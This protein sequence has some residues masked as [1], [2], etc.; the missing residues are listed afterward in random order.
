MRSFL[1]HIFGNDISQF[2]NIISLNTFIFVLLNMAASRKTRFFLEEL[3]EK[4]VSDIQNL[5]KMKWR[6]GMFF[7]IEDFSGCRY[8]K[9]PFILHIN[10]ER[11][12]PVLEPERT[13][14]FVAMWTVALC[15]LTDGYQTFGGKYCFQIF[16]ICPQHW[17]QPS[18]LQG[19]KNA[20]ARTFALYTRTVYLLLLSPYFTT[21]H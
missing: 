18:A 5:W 16:Y 8:F 17:Y 14:P 6:Q 2:K 12:S 15:D 20:A 1:D 4:S 19:V 9:F 13:L 11:P 21:C 10:L 7:F 3:N